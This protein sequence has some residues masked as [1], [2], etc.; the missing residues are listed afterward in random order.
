MG[1]NMHGDANQTLYQLARQLRNNATNAENILWD[2]LKKKPLGFKFR[3]QHPYSVYILDFYCHRLK[4]VIEVDGA[5][6]NT[7][8]VKQN[9]IIRQ[10]LLE[11]EGMAVIRFQNKQVEKDLH[12]VMKIIEEFLRK[13][14]NEL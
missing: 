9:D 11:K 10:R 4:F 6:H 7:E 8:D 14:T 5:I 3:R 2:Y 13:K 12:G 1:R